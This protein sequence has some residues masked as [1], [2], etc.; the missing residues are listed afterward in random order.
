MLADTDDKDVLRPSVIIKEHLHHDPILILISLLPRRERK[1]YPAGI[2]LW[3]LLI[4]MGVRVVPGLPEVSGSFIR[5]G[6][7]A[8]RPSSR[9]VV[10]DACARPAW[11][12]VLKPQQ[13]SSAA[14]ELLDN[15]VIRYHIF[16]F[17]SCITSP[18]MASML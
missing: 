15:C 18:P 4:I 8:L 9:A 10:V 5:K 16:S 17:F 6:H 2:S 13:L 12:N 1:Q 11:L 14:Y 7:P 3:F